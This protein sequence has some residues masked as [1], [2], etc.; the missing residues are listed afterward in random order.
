MLSRT[1]YKDTQIHHYIAD[2]TQK[3]NICWQMTWE[4]HFTLELLKFVDVSAYSHHQA[5][6]T[7]CSLMSFNVNSFCLHMVNL[8]HISSSSLSTVCCITQLSDATL[9]S[10]NLRELLN[11]WSLWPAN[12]LKIFNQISLHL[13]A[14]ISE[15]H[16][17]VSTSV[18]SFKLLYILY[19]KTKQNVKDVAQSSSYQGSGSS[20][21]W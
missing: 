8:S 6:P 12:L 2:N 18:W 9:Q 14:W 11:I 16:H 13:L 17:L 15:K 4:E 19:K 3:Q 5:S 21:P 10:N 7:T 1:S 20:F